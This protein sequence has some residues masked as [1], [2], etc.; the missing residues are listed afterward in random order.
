M[1]RLMTGFL[2]IM[3]W[4]DLLMEAVVACVKLVSGAEEIP[5]NYQHQ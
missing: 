3:N 5:E 4:K 2:I 1:K